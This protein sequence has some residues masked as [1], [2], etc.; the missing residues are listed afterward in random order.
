[1]ITIYFET[2]LN[3]RSTN[4]RISE[5]MYVVDYFILFILLNL[6]GL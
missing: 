2:L 4:N 5:I 1:M 6:E 3:M